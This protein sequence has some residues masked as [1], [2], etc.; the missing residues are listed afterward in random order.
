MDELSDEKILFLCEKYGKAAL[1]WRQK[2][3]GLL[4]EVQRRAL[5][6]TKNFNSI[7]EFA[8]KLAGLSEQQVKL[9]LKLDRDFHDLPALRQAFTAGIVSINKLAR[10]TSIATKENEVELAELVTVLPREAL[11]TYVRDLRS[12]SRTEAPPNL[13][14]LNLSVE[15]LTRLKKLQDQGK[16]LS[17][18]LMALLDGHEDRLIEERKS[19]EIVAKPTHSRHIPIRTRQWL[20]KEYGTKCAISTCKKQ[21]EEVHHSDRFSVSQRHDPKFLAPLCHGHHQVAHAVDLKAQSHWRGS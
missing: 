21:A 12:S 11:E 5:Y 18:L 16:D 15:L 3:I 14:D 8:F 19:I 17:N 1:Y 2:F 6:K 20:V 7:F 4:P 9:A 10:V 13:L